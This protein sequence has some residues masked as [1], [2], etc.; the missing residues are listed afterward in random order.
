MKLSKQ[1]L[2]RLGYEVVTKTSSIDALN[3]IQAKPEKFDLIITDMTMP[4]MTGEKLAQE[5]MHIVPN[6]PIILCT[7][8]NKMITEKKAKA[9]GIRALVNK[10]VLMH[11][12]AEIIRKVLDEK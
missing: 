9:T 6:I 1:M 2:E 4:N 7:G 5:L 12:I 10:P 11:E 8:F 3:L